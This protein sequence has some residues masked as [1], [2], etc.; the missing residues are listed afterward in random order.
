LDSPGDQGCEVSVR[1]RVLVRNR[2]PDADTL[3]GVEG[4]GVHGRLHPS[5]PDPSELLQYERCYYF[6]R[7]LFVNYNSYK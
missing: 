1:N 2:V 3:H 5:V 4:Y 6:F 7:L